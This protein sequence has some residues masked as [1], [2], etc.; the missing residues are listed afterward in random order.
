[1]RRFLASLV[2]LPTLGL[3]QPL[4]F[5]GWL[6]HWDQG[7]SMKSYE[8]NA[9]AIQRVAP[10]WVEVGEDGMPRHSLSATVKVM[11]RAKVLAI[12][13]KAG[14]QVLSLASNYNSAKGDFD[15]ELTH[16]FLADKAKSKAHAAALV[17]LAKDDG[18]DGIDLDYESLKGSDREAYSRFTEMVAEMAHAQ[19]LKLA[20]A[21]HP[22]LS[23]P[24]DWDGAQ[25]QDWKRLG[26]AVD[27]FRPMAYDNHWVTSD[28]G[29]IAPPDWA[30]KVL[31]F[32]MSLV[33][34]SKIELGVPAYGYDWK[35]KKGEGLDWPMFQTLVSAKGPAKRDKATGEW[36]FKYADRE[37]WFADSQAMRPKFALAKKKG[38]LG[39]GMWRLGSEDPEFWKV[40]KDLR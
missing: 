11:D 40:L 29:P 2:L 9:A 31:N 26:S 7:A 21:L 4:E 15:A 37:V 12:A 30:E 27:Y 5:T 34:A 1:M 24:G 8:A 28:A 32:A 38:I 23:E 25:A 22:K 14:S 10:G 19:G 3:A 13:R 39:L 6:V 17:K 33:P 16:L 18:A 36:T 35:Q 20:I